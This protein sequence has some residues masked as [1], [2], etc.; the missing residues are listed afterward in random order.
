MLTLRIHSTLRVLQI[1]L[2]RFISRQKSGHL[3]VLPPLELGVPNLLVLAHSLHLHIQRYVHYLGRKVPDI[4]PRLKF[5]R[6]SNAI[7]YTNTVLA[8]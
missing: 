5:S 4:Q 7:A 3:I 1:I 2:V 6:I 8:T